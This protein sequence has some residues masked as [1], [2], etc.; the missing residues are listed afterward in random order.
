MSYVLN[1]VSY[2]IPPGYSQNLTLDR[3]SVIRF[4][5]AGTR[6]AR[7][8]LEP[9]L[10]TFTNTDHGWE[11]YHAADPQPASCQSQRTRCQ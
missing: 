3:A 11:L 1:N 8:G 7:C 2:S 6:S 5:L 9:G 10:Y 4:S